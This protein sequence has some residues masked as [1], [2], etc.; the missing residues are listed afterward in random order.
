MLG[1]SDAHKDTSRQSSE[2]GAISSDGGRWAYMDASEIKR[3]DSYHCSGGD[4]WTSWR[5]KAGA[6]PLMWR[7]CYYEG[8]LYS[9][10]LNR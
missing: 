5:E 4:G 7:S 6:E 10:G 2:G 1:P 3:Q 8:R 9:K